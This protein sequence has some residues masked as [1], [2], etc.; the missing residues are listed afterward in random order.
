M[1]NYDTNLAAEFYVLSVLHRLGMSATLTL[2]NKKSVDIVVARDA[3]NAF[4]IDVKGLAGTT[5]W[6][7][8]NLKEGKNG[9]FI[10]FV[11][12]RGKIHD[13]SISPEVYIVPSEEV[14]GAIY[15]NPAGNR[16]VIPLGR[17]RKVW[18]KFKNG[19]DILR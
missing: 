11:S 17:A 10:A 9:H 2:G 14:S 15:Q 6:P 12:F 3:G 13:P 5:N 19:W 18:G 4:T 16:R 1:S 7:V 8:D